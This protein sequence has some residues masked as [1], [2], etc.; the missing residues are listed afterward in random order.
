M[1]RD[2][3]HYEVKQALTYDGWNVTDDP[4]Y[5]KIGTI[6]IHID[7]GAEKIIGAEKD[8]EKIAVEIKTFGMLSFITAFHEAVGKYIVYREALEIIE[9][10]R[11]L[12]LAM[13]IDTYEEFSSELL[14][15]RVLA[16]NKIKL[17]LYE[18][19]TQHIVSWLK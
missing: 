8:G 3:F 2:K 6:P 17:I 14:V 15:Q 18:A 12:Y 10:D 4:L 9:S 16:K 5:I 19:S 7:L 11:V 13:P 1:A